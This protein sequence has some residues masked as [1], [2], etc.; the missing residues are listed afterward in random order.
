MVYAIKPRRKQV[1]LFL[2]GLTCG[3]CIMESHEDSME[4][5]GALRR[6][7]YQVRRPRGLLEKR[8]VCSGVLRVKRYLV[9]V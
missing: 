8:E 3:E 1:S 5:W 6:T 2:T 9:Q 4:L 7:S